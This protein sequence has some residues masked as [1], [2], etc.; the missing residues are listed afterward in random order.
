MYHFERGG[1]FDER[2]TLA[3]LAVDT[4]LRYWCVYP[5][6]RKLYPMLLTEVPD[7]GRIRSRMYER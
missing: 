1:V 5:T 3:V 6:A 2:R 4:R 7:R